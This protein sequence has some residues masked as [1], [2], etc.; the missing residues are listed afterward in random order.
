MQE[1]RSQVDKPAGPE[2]EDLPE[3]QELHMGRGAQAQ[4]SE[5][6]KYEAAKVALAEA[7]RVDE[8]LQIRNV[9]AAMSAAA[10]IANDKQLEI[11]ASEIRIRAERRLGEMIRAQK[12]GEGLA[13]GGRPK[14]TPT[15]E[16]GVYNPTLADVGID[17]KLS[18]RSQ[19][20]A[21]IP[22]DEFEEVLDEHREQQQAVTASTLQKLAKK[23][24]EQKEKLRP[25]GP[26]SDGMQFAR[27]AI[28]NLEQIKN[29]DVER[30]EAFAVVK[31]WII[32]HEN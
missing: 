27:I 1:V 9:T 19:A 4:M 32:K 12:D 16:E 2:T 15:T 30:V 11:D 20:I 13:K 17:Y 18:S 6:V 26:P 5:L 22:E 7:K 21:S 28:M 24:G 3:V 25:I 23:G 29:N 8:V 14:E 31:D 10:R